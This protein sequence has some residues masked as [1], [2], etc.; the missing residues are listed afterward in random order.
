MKK[1]LLSA[2]AIMAA[3]SVNAQEV[4]SIDGEAL[5]LTSDGVAL[6]AGTVLCETESISMTAGADDTYKTQSV[7]ATVGDGEIDGG[8]QGSTNPKDADGGNPATT[9]IAPAGG[10]FF[11]FIAK[12]D[13][14]VYVIHKASSNKN[15]TVFEEKEA[16]GYTF[17]AIG[18][19]STILGAVYN[20]TLVGADEY[21]HI[22]EPIE[23]AEQ[24]ALKQNNPEAYEA[25]F[26]VAE[27]GTKTW[28]KIG[29]GGIGVIKFQVFKDCKYIVNACG[30][31]M[32]AGGFYYDTTGD[33]TVSVTDGD[34][35]TTVILNG[36]GEAGVNNLVIKETANGAVFNI[37]GQKV[38][39]SFKGISVKNGKKFIKK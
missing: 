5:G 31:K 38:S 4:A 2:V 39:N 30:S 13:G 14:W 24:E 33:A 34:G 17:A 26:T 8:C 25:N 7:K 36:S 18:D 28:T 10:A 3:M 35:N 32:T 6:T 21:N 37:A 1:V 22:V 29:K 27:D 19:A 9:L 12:A 16:I 15:Y 11:E 20:Y 23:W